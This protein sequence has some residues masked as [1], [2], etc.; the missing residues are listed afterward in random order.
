M[1]TNGQKI[2]LITGITGMDGSLLAE[3]LLKKNY[4]V[5]GMRR[6]TST[7]NTSRLE[8]L[9]ANPNFIMEWGNVTDNHSIIK[10]LTKYK[11]DE[12][13]NLAAQSHVRVSFDVP[14]ETFEVVTMGTLNML[15]AMKEICPKAKLYQ[16]SSSEMYGVAIMPETG[17]TEESKMLPASPYAIAKLA[18]HNLVRNYR[19]SYNLH[20]SC[21]ILFNHEQPGLRGETFVTRKIAI[22]AAKIKT[23]TQQKLYLGNLDSKRDWGLASEYV[24]GMWLMLQQ[25]NPDDYVLAT[26]ETHTV[27]DFL[28]EVFKHANLDTENHV[29]IEKRLFRPEEVP[30]LLGDYSKAKKILGWEP[31][32][33]FKALAKDMYQYEIDNIVR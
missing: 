5:I 28:Q 1:T 14:D 19:E 25:P 33:K 3:F 15:N 26:G 29:V 31:K 17:Y 13:Y 8:H 27:N 4:M 32:T 30:I 24:E 23:G 11:P 21:G 18:A 10:I 6:R 9:Y 20:A 16:A 7:F 12:I 2:A 22:A